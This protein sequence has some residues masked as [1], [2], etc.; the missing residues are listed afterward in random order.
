[1]INNFV[2]SWQDQLKVRRAYYNLAP[3]YHPDRNPEG[4]EQFQQINSAYEFLT[5]TLVRN[6]NSIIPDIQRLVICL[7]AQCIVYSRYLKGITQN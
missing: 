4:R 1:M 5:S 2:F 3:K 7:Q 6:K